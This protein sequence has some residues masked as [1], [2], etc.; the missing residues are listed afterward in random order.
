ML[1]EG[2]RGEKHI[3]TKVGGIIG[4]GHS[5]EFQKPADEKALRLTRGLGKSLG[6]FP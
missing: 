3:D 5:E 4:A 1:L 6:A 2:R